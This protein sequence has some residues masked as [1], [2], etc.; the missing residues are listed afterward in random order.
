MSI[1]KMNREELIQLLWDK[2]KEGVRLDFIEDYGFRKNEEPN[3]ME[4][5]NRNLNK[6]HAEIFC[7]DGIMT[8]LIAYGADRI[9][10]SF[11]Y[12]F[13]SFLSE[14]DEAKITDE[15][16]F[17]WFS[18]AITKYFHHHLIEGHQKFFVKGEIKA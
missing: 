1:V 17:K 12:R 10:D 14:K 9:R 6:F 3:Q 16:R 5:S 2:H 11:V 4:W 18:D 8:L 7:F 13:T 15:K